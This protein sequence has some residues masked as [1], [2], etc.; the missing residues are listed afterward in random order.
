MRF[1]RVLFLVM[2]VGLS[3]CEN[4]E[5]ARR[6]QIKKNLKQVGLALHAD[7]ANNPE[8]ADISESV[9]SGK[10]PSVTTHPEQEKAA[11]VDPPHTA[12]PE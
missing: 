7:H 5:A 8:P 12:T 1:F 11:A 4:R 9:P 3:G 2:L 10:T 6:E